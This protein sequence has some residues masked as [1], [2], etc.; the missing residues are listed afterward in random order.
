MKSDKSNLD[1]DKNAN[2]ASKKIHVLNAPEVQKRSYS[3]QK[4][5][6]RWTI[7]SFFLFVLA[8]LAVAIYYYTTIAADRYAVETKFAIRTASGSAPTDFLG[9]V[10]SVSSTTSTTTD[11]YIIVDFIESRDLID[12]L[13]ARLDIVG[14]YSHPDADILTRLDPNKILAYASQDYQYPSF[15][16]NALPEN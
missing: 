13:N 3:A 6:R 8:P 15:Q 12:R 16:P 5:R 14:I 1:K 11:S 2:D 4:K 10:S 7:A 9:I